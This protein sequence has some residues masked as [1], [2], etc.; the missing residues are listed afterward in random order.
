MSETLLWLLY[1]VSGVIAFLATYYRRWHNALAVLAGGLVTTI[2]WLLLFRFTAEEKRPDWV[3]LDLSLNVT[4]GLI[5]SAIGA[6]LGWWLLRRRDGR[7][8]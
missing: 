3:Q 7:A 2:G 8:D 5:F 4:F 1:G 6:A